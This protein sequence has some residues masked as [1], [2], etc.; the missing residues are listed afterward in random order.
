LL[1]ELC[2]VKY[3][4]EDDLIL[5]CDSCNKGYHLFCLRPP[6]SEVPKGEY[7]C[8]P[9]ASKSLNLKE[10]KIRPSSRRSLDDRL[11]KAVAR[12]PRASIERIL[13]E[14]TQ[15]RG[16]GNICQLRLKV[17]KAGLHIFKSLSSRF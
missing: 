1:C 10:P 5:L 14:L 6:L 9:C 16:E 12:L 2:G 4:D 3:E 13:K 11:E 8:P 15:I 17:S 7:F